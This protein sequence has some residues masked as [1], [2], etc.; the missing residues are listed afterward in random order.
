MI[1]ISFAQTTDGRFLAATSCSPYFCFESPTLET[2]EQKVRNALAFYDA[3]KANWV[4]SPVDEVS[5]T[6]FITQRV[7]SSEELTAAA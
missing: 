7:V 5:V 2:L 1:D 4:P 6:R 3:N